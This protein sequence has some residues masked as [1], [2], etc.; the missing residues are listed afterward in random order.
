MYFR[1]VFLC[2]HY[3][4]ILIQEISKDLK[5]HEEPHC[6]QHWVR[7]GAVTLKRRALAVASAT[8]RPKSP[9]PRSTNSR[10][11]GGSKRG[12]KSWL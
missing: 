11:F 6:L 12:T 5:K 3:E 8:L 9:P 7:V 10:T 4:L 2:R 1:L